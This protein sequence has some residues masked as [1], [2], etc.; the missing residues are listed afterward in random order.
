[1]LTATLCI[2]RW[3]LLLLCLFARRLVVD[4]AERLRRS[5]MHPDFVAPRDRA[6]I[7]GYV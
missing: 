1:M 4:G 6:S 5:L 7:W 2:N 3:M